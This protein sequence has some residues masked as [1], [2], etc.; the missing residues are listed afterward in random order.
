MQSCGAS[1]RPACP[2]CRTLAVLVVFTA[3]KVLRFMLTVLFKY[4]C[5]WTVLP[6]KSM[7]AQNAV[8]VLLLPQTAVRALSQN[9]SA[10]S[11]PITLLT[12]QAPCWA[13]AVSILTAVTMD[14][15]QPW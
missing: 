10:A 8:Q 1:H 7:L 15:G 5:W 12:L 6:R 2:N 9:Q 14:S 13:S 11:A 3:I 4:S